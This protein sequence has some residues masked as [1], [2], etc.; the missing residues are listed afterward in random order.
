MLNSSA[1]SADNGNHRRISGASGKID[2]SVG[3]AF[4]RNS[5]SYLAESMSLVLELANQKERGKFVSLGCWRCKYVRHYP[6]SKILNYPD[7]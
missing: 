5:L 7:R 6:R 4:A 1:V 3:S 2:V